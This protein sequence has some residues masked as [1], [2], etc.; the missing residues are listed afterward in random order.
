MVVSTLD[1]RAPEQGPGFGIFAEGASLFFGQWVR[2]SGGWDA[3]TDLRGYANLGDDPGA[4][5]TLANRNTLAGSRGLNPSS[6]PDSNLADILA[7]FIM[8]TLADPAGV[9]RVKPLRFGKRGLELYLAGQLVL[10]EPIN[11]AHPNFQPTLDV[12]W[13][14]YRRH[15]A[16]GTSLEVLQRWTGAC[17]LKY[18]GREATSADI[19]QLLPTEHRD[20]GATRPRTTIT[21]SFSGDLTAW[22]Q[23]VG[24]WSISGGELI[25]SRAGGA[26]EDGHI[27]HDTDLS[28]DDHTAHVNPLQRVGDE[29]SNEGGLDVRCNSANSVRYH[30][31]IDRTG[32]NGY[33]FRLRRFDSTNDPATLA[34]GAGIGLSDAT[35]GTGVDIT[36][37]VDGS[38][39][40]VS[41]VSPE[42]SLNVT[43]TAITGNLRTGCAGRL[44]STVRNN[45]DNFEATDGISGAKR[46]SFFF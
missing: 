42:A 18:F 33:R 27:R 21:D 24:S 30:G 2:G 15:K 45:W 22:T 34:T 32:T 20:D 44:F 41:T 26:N 28:D 7:H 14:D 38:T 5:M 9:N 11:P 19:D 6:L 4:R 8:G 3:P 17:G 23:M 10:K 16:A 43:N 31:Q 13:A 35:F 12:R 37:D 36:V 1:L 25:A 29:T 40:T 46:S 39:L